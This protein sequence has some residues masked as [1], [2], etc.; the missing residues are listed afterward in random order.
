[1]MCRDVVKLMAVINNRNSFGEPV[2]SLTPREVF[3]NKKSVK[4]AEFY[5]AL[6]TGIRPEIVFEIRE[7]EYEGETVLEY[8]GRKYDIIR[9]YSRGGDWVELTCSR[10]PLRGG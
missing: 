5:Q 9:T 7:V 3:A 4:G 1:M 10:S 8:E 6:A 2:Q